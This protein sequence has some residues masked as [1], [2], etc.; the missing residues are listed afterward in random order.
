MYAVPCPWYKNG[1]CTSPLL[2]TPSAD[3]V[4]PQRCLSDAS[5]KDC[6]YFK[7]LSES[8]ISP[9][10]GKPLLLIHSLSTQPRCSCEYFIYTQHE[11]GTYV[12]ACKVLRRYLTRYE[13]KL[14]EKKWRECPFRKIGLK[15][16][17]GTT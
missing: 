16:Q 8:N 17:Q 4:I 12:A 11:S 5:Y 6:K 3:P 15:L 10:Y 7:D 14:C 9:N 13:V 2:D 1:M